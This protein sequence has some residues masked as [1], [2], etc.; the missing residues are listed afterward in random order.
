MLSG[1]H[2]Q[3]RVLPKWLLDKEQK[4]AILKCVL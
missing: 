3:A 2:P 1:L 4:L